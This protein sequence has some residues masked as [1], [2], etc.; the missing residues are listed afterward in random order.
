[1][2]GV[3]AQHLLQVPAMYQHYTRTKHKQ[4]KIDP[5]GNS[6]TQKGDTFWCRAC[7]E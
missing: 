1:M 3:L 6:V 7:L 2:R 5:E 4:L